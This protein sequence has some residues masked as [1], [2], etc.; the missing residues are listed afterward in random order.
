[1][2]RPV[3]N[4]ILLKI[5]ALIF[6]LCLI[7]MAYSA[8]GL[9]HGWQ[10][11]QQATELRIVQDMTRNFSDGL[12]NFMFERGRMNV[13][14]SKEAPVSDENKAFLKERRTSADEA[15]LA[16]FAAMQKNFPEETEYLRTEYEK[17]DALRSVADTE[18]D[19]PLSQR[20][21][22]I[23]ERWFGCCSG[24]IDT[25][26]SEINVIRQ[27]SHNSNI[28]NSFDV[29]VDSL[30]FRSIVGNESSI[31]TSAIAGNGKISDEEHAKLQFLL[32][33]EAQVW[34]ELE[35][36]VHILGSD[37]IKIALENVRDQYYVKFRPE[38]E[39]IL[40]LAIKNQWYDGMD[41]ELANLSVPA[42]DS[43][44]HLS[45][46]AVDQIGIEN[47]KSIQ[48]GL[49][50]LLAG[51]F[52]LTTGLFIVVLIPLFFRRKFVQ[53][54]TDIISALNEISVGKVEGQIPHTH[55][56]DEI[57]KLAHGA[58]LLKNSITDEQALKREL[59]NSVA[60]LA[61]LSV[62]DSLTAL[63]NR[64]YMAERFD[65]LVKRHTRT[66]RVFSVI[67]CDID[68]FKSFN[69][70]HGHACGDK[71]LVHISSQ[72]SAYCRESDVLARWGG[73]EFL[74]LL[75]DTNQEGAMVLAERIRVG[76]ENTKYECERFKLR[77]TMTFGI[78]EYR[79]AEDMAGTAKRADLALMKGKRS[80]RNQVVA[81]DGEPGEDERADSSIPGEMT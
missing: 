77:L 22:G 17:V 67:M 25:V 51:I 60:K 39:R 80:G 29:V 15:F 56:A 33:K 65:E 11:Y 18:A 6:V 14:L 79:E 7:I 69:D 70:R 48:N 68:H 44:L 58:E 46:E 59:E 62:K 45:D 73:E 74:L 28:S 61:D 31:I 24:Y 34:S 66:G 54:V 13:V 42:L 50:G 12:K 27:L 47:Q 4:S 78:A 64:R 1:M 72:L 5:S 36:T 35:K 40:E 23:R 43:V 30:Y 37:K 81:F 53:P 49:Q 75:P 16:G 26:I 2:M 21:P 76:L 3:R 38:Q 8:N 19:K 55:R 20:D 41:R 9:Y 32:G 57:G 63:Y 10:S 71:V 52:Q